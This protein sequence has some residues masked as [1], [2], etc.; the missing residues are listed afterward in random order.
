[1]MDEEVI[2]SR[3]YDKQDRLMPGNRLST[4]RRLRLAAGLARR[5]VAR[6]TRRASPAAKRGF[7]LIELLVVIGVIALLVGLLLPAV[8]RSYRTA[9]RARTQA[10]LALIGTA[11]DA[12][13]QDFGDYPRF[14]D[15]NAANA[16]GVDLNTRTD[17]GAILLC[18]A[19]IGP[20]G[21][22]VDGANGLGFRVRG[23]QGKIYGPYLQ[24]DK[25]KLSTDTGDPAN[26]YAKI[27]DR[28]G[29]PILY[30]PA[31][32]GSPN[33]TAPSGFDALV[34]P[35]GYTPATPPARPLYN[36]YDNTQVPSSSQWPAGLTLLSPTEMQY[37]LG[38]RDENGQINSSEVAT[39]TG[40]YI[41]WTA[42]D[43]GIYGRDPKTGKT[44]DVTNFDIPADLRK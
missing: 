14:D 8:L 28:N 24:A 20:G 13:R 21:Q 44:D 23:T 38:D 11:L 3:G 17:R 22:G 29:N 6:P 18:Q 19:L 2:F 36:A 34:S 16:G 1:M 30:Y 10:D 40:P 15:N 9:D 27:L 41:L 25:F 35:P 5:V 12:Y 32:P 37:I 7:T 33:I 39:F 31:T 26:A 4:S 43:D 42:G